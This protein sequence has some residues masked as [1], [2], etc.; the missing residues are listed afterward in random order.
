MVSKTSLNLQ[1]NTPPFLSVFTPHLLRGFNFSKLNFVQKKPCLIVTTLRM[2][3]SGCSRSSPRVTHH[4]RF[5]C[6]EQG[7]LANAVN[8]TTILTR[9]GHVILP[10][11]IYF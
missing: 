11:S 8:E 1:V 5:V 4:W 9:V 6:F 2:R 10:L 3:L 7:W